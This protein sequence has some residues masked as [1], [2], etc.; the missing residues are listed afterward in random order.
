MK[1]QKRILTPL[2]FWSLSFAAVAQSANPD[3][4]LLSG[5]TNPMAKNL[6]ADGEARA[7]VN[8]P[9]TNDATSVCQLMRLVALQNGLPFEFFARV[10]WQESRFKSDAV[11][12]LTRGGQ[13]AQGIAQF[14]PGTAAERLLQDPFDPAE[15]L[16]K[17]G[18]FLRDLRAQFGNLG[19]AAAAYNAGPQRVKDWLAGKKS[20]PSETENYVRNIT[21]RAAAEWMRAEQTPLT[22]TVPND[23]SC[24]EIVKLRQKP[25]LS[26]VGVQPKPSPAW[27]VQLVGD[28]S[29]V[30]ALA[31]FRRLQTKHEA[32]LKDYE[33][34][35]VRTT[36]KGSPI[37]ARV[38]IDVSTR[39][40]AQLLCSN[41]RTAGEE[42]LVQR[43]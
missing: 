11:G 17:S 34:E 22:L 24:L 27:V 13:R 19:L 12:P 16:P 7:A 43:N 20:L 5:Q 29:E 14:M 23:M 31:L 35:I 28:R 21:G 15:A 38:R 25:R 41:L 9:T 4:N 40:A 42:C 37:W 3:P 39:E 36:L 1:F 6:D 32:L 8:Q 33:P 18:E 10:I 30:Q 2:A 26:S